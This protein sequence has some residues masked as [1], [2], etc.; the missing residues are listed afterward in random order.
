[1]KLGEALRQII[2]ENGTAVIGEERLP[3]LLAGKDALDI[4]KNTYFRTQYIDKTKKFQS[5]ERI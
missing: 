2:S 1:M 4:L 5:D 3:E